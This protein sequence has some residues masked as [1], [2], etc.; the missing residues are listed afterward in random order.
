MPKGIFK[1][2]LLEKSKKVIVKL[3]KLILIIRWIREFFLFTI[4]N[5]F[6]G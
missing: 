2:N 4:F 5:Y 3:N 1:S 6:K